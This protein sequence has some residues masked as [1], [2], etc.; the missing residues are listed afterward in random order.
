MQ[1]ACIVEFFV[2]LPFTE[3]DA[4]ELVRRVIRV[5]FKA[6]ETNVFQLREQSFSIYPYYTYS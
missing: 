5:S 4:F 3:S 2:R 1:R 6:T